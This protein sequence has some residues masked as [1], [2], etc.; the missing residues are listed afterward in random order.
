MKILIW[1]LTFLFFGAIFR[2]II[3]EAMKPPPLPA[4]PPKEPDPPVFN[5]NIQV[6]VTEHYHTHNEMKVTVVRAEPRE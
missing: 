3:L 4:P 1:T 5:Q 2:S 6:N